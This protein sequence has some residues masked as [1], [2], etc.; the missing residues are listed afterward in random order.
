VFQ[1]RYAEL[2]FGSV[3]LALCLIRRRF[4]HDCRFP[5]HRIMRLRVIEHCVCCYAALYQVTDR[6]F[7]VQVKLRT[8]P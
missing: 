3:L 5:L 2:G 7:F 6:R 4:P 1:I 8:R